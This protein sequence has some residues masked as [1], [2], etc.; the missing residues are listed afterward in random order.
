MWKNSSLA[1]QCMS[2]NINICMVCK[3]EDDW[4]FATGMKLAIQLWTYLFFKCKEILGVTKSQKVL[5]MVWYLVLM[6]K[7]ILNV[8]CPRIRNLLSTLLEQWTFHNTNIFFF[9]FLVTES[10]NYCLVYPASIK[11]LLQFWRPFTSGRKTCEAEDENHS[12]DQIWS[13]FCWNFFQPFT[14]RIC[15]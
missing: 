2:F 8:K 9:F 1:C 11:S 4:K 12:R 5:Y 13:N 15:R 14:F 10:A 3:L 7:K 6:V